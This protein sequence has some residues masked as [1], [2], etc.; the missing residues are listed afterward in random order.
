MYGRGR[1]SEPDALFGA[2][3]AIKEKQA[4]GSLSLAIT[5]NNLGGVAQD[6]GD[7]DAARSYFD[8][9]L[10]IQEKQAPGSLSLAMTL[11]DLGLVAWAR[12]DLDAA[13]SYYDKALAIK[14]KQAPGSLSLAET[15]NNLGYVQRRQG[16]RHGS[17]QLL[18]RSWEIAMRQGSRIA[19]DEARRAF[20][21]SQGRLGV[22]LVHWLG[23]DGL[24]EDAF[25]ILEEGRAQALQQVLAERGLNRAGVAP[26]A[27]TAYTTASAAADRAVLMT[28]SH[29]TRL[30]RLATFVSFRSHRFS[31]DTGAET[32]RIARFRSPFSNEPRLGSDPRT[33]RRWRLFILCVS[34]REARC[35]KALRQGPLACT[36]HHSGTCAEPS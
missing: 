35:S 7:L 5:L 4:P 15:L 30:F 27:W 22:R 32:A 1:L 2:S 28:V 17:I 3:L 29:P 16:D 25:R 33:S 21:A 13:R 34:P 36:V 23:E 31:P 26:A 18:R 11:N 12:G 10:V 14:E 6:R 24:P 20:G 9:A 8:K 19:G